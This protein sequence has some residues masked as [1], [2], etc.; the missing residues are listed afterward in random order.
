MGTSEPQPIDVRF[1]TYGTVREDGEGRWTFA[2]G[3]SALDI[4]TPVEQPLTGS[5]DSPAGWIRKVSV[6]DLRAPAAA[7]HAWVTVLYP[8][9]ASDPLVSPVHVER[10][11]NEIVVSVGERRISFARHADG[12]QI[13][14]AR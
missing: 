2:T 5:I 6:L 11:E 7:S 3:T 1:H 4:A 13:Q 9:L 8:R 12:W 14:S 10:R